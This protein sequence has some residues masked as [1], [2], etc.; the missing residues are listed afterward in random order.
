MDFLSGPSLPQIEE[1]LET[2]SAL[3]AAAFLQDARRSAVV[4]QPDTNKE[5]NDFLEDETFADHF[6]EPRI[7][8]G[9]LAARAS[10]IITLVAS[11]RSSRAL[12]RLG[13]RCSIWRGAGHGHLALCVEWLAQQTGELAR[14]HHL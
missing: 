4:L 11:L 10:S 6:L 13:R 5:Q 8:A 2:S 12:E 9:K 7:D 14:G 3:E 1:A